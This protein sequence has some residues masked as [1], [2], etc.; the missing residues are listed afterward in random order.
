MMTLLGNMLKCNRLTDCQ[1]IF[2]I[3]QCTMLNISH[4]PLFDGHQ[5]QYGPALA[6]AAGVPNRVLVY[7]PLGSGKT[8][9]AVHAARTFLEKM[10]GGQVFVFTTKA[11]IQPTWASNLQLY[12]SACTVVP[13]IPLDNVHNPDWWF[14]LQN[15]SVAHYNKLFQAL[16]LH[17]PRSRCMSETCSSLHSLCQVHGL[18][19]QWGTFRTAHRKKMR[20]KLTKYI[21]KKDVKAL[22]HKQYIRECRR[23]NININQSMLQSCLPT[24]PYL[25]I[26]DECQDYLHHSANESL[27]QSLSDSASFTLLLSATP[28]HDA[29]NASSLYRLLGETSLLSHGAKFLYTNI[30]TGKPS[31]RTVTKEVPL[32]T[33]EWHYHQSVSRERLGGQ[34]QNAYLCRTRQACNTVSKWEAMAA[35]LERDI[36][37]WSSGPLRIVVYSYFL[38][39]GVTGFWDYLKSRLNGQISEARLR[40][41][42]GRIKV[43]CSLMGNDDNGMHWFN[44]ER[45]VGLTT[46]SVKI[47]LLSSR[48]GQGISLKNVAYFHLMEPQWSTAEEEQ[49]IGRTTRKNSHTDIPP[50]VQ[51]YQ[52][53]ATPPAHM[54]S[55]STADQQMI[56]TKTTKEERTKR[57]LAQW[58]HAGALRLAELLQLQDTEQKGRQ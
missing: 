43:R 26:I 14:S 55:M 16:A 18:T 1:Y 23:Y 32:T 48:S 47:L 35:Q 56:R 41:Q 37:S 6:V 20:K 7:Y 15:K 27:V 51:L 58:Q 54:I 33:E 17:V 49:A 28:V 24:T 19:R 31:V 13:P 50:Q 9:A 10:P 11:N 52:W 46:A 21:R 44:K 57:L 5:F 4:C 34:C 45:T 8:L 22:D 42:V 2:C 40:F 53:V 25:L 36:S 3:S 38:E 29:R 30:E 39:H 12:S